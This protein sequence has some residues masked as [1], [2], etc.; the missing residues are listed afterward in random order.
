MSF[1]L[2]AVLAAVLVC[3]FPVYSQAQSA[4]TARGSVLDAAGSSVAN[5][6][7]SITS[8][9]TGA[10]R[11]SVT[12]AAGEFSFPQLIPGRYR[13]DVDASGF[14]HL[15]REGI[16]LTTGTAAEIDLSLSVGAAAQTVTV[17]ADAPLLQVASSDIQ[18]SI[19]R[20]SVV[21]LPLNGRNFIQLATLAPGVSLPPGTLLPRI[22]GGRP[23]TN[24]YLFDGISALQPEP[25]Q[26]AFFPIIDDIQEFTVQANNVPAEFGRFNGGVVNLSTR[27]GSNA[28]HGSLYEFFRNEQLNARNY[29]ASPTARKPEYRRNQFGATLGAPVLRD[30]LFFF[31]GYQGEQQAIGITR[32]ST[33]PTLA[34]RQGI[35]TGVAHIFNPSTTTFAH[36]AYTRA[37]VRQRRHH[38]P[39]RPGCPEPPRSHPASDQRRRGEQLQPNRERHRS[40]EPVRLPRGRQ[41][42]R[43]RPRLRPLLLLPRCGKSGRALPGGQRRHHRLGHRHRK[44]LRAFA[45]AR[46]AGSAQRDPHLWHA[47][48]QRPPCRVHAAQQ[49]HRRSV[50]ARHGQLGSGHPRHS[51]R[52]RF[53]QCASALHADRLPADRL[54]SQRLLAVPDRGMGSWSTPFKSMPA[55]MRS[56]S[57]AISAGTS[58]MPSLPQ[59]RPARSPS[60]RPVPTS[61]GWRFPRP[62][63][64]RTA[65][66]SPA[67]C[68]GRSIPS[69]SI[70]RAARFDRATTSR[71]SSRRMTGVSPRS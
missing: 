47:S 14:A 20:S 8:E 4:A 13:M 36:G 28:L 48:A 51:H 43:K 11:T 41:P 59:T 70:S 6:R 38:Q 15:V 69:L 2:R 56:S 5:A 39:A 71:S 46:P 1:N 7:V 22:N 65:T 67:F 37:G 68:W 23:R 35:F 10:K 64:A 42:R 27:S 40:S 60:R 53:F 55:A 3:L 16:V 66:R 50:S 58:S 57:A 49:Q 25:G 18:T 33:V 34:E 30:R 44:R 63:N 31:G 17:T 61:R 32:I 24:E 54:L 52:L 29:F 19:P 45:R 26:V 9:A 12:G 21:G 62:T